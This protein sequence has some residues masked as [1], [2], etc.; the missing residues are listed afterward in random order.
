MEEKAKYGCYFYV[1]TGEEHP[2]VFTK[3]TGIQPTSIEVKGERAPTKDGRRPLVFKTNFWELK[4]PVRIPEKKDDIWDICESILD[5]TNIF[6][7][8][9]FEVREALQKFEYK[10]LVIYGDV[11]TCWLQFGAT[12]E[13]LYKMQKYNIPIKFSIMSCESEEEEEEEVVDVWKNEDGTATAI[14][15]F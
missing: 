12:P 10:Q 1:N 11:Y 4:P 13:I 14:E 2:D 8:K 5:I 7:E 15:N 6:D 9:E 3:L